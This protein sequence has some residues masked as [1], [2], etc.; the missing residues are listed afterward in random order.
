VKRILV[1]GGYGGFGSR[2]ARRL[3]EAGHE[4][5]VAG[6][7]LEKAQAFCA[8]KPRMRPL[9]LNR[10]DG[11]K[12]PLADER[13]WAVVDAAGPF[14]VTDYAVAEAAVR[15]GCHYI[16]IADARSFVAG[17]GALDGAARGARVTVLSG[18]SSTPALSGAAV[19][20]LA[21]SMGEIRAIEI[22]ISASNRATAGPS[23]TRAILSYVGK[24]V[25]LW[26]GGRWAPGY[27][28]QGMKRQSFEVAGIPPIAP[29]FVGLVD[30]PD[31]ELLPE[32]LAGRPAIS[33]RAGTE[34]AIQNIGLWMLSWPVRWAWL[35]SLEP[36]APLFLRA[37]RLTRRFGSDRSAMTV[38]LF[39]LG[40]SRLERRWT[41][42]AS[43]GD[44]P[45]IPGLAVPILLQ[46]LTRGELRPGARDA[47]N[48]LDLA[49]FEPAFAQLSIRHEVR[50]FEQ[51]LPLYE[52]VMGARFAALPDA[53][54]AMHDVLRD[55]GAAG[56]AT[57][58]QGTNF[59]ARLLHRA[60]RFPPEGEH[61]LHVD[62][63]ERNGTERWT[64]TFGKHHRFHSHLYERDGMLVERFGPLRF[65]FDLP[66]DAKGLRMA[67]RRWWLGP[68]PLPLWLAPRSAARE[69]EEDGLFWFDVP[70]ALPLIGL[71]VHYRGWLVP[72]VAAAYSNSLKR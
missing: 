3:W 21:K 72:S 48:L 15:A 34:L 38:R 60:M 8:G 1:L 2:I 25:P 50:D 16:D 66:S 58:R 63:T 23:V 26:R 18:A 61:P 69:W 54:R 71:I 12:K 44:G 11:L 28:W 47:G 70:I 17:I 67:M 5:V 46:R 40:S 53:V 45:E 49:E 56:R 35:G 33:F 6:R 10:S 51:P 59:H 57:V 24:P 41:L 64:R 4:V 14:Q 9:Q 36:L 32:R 65:A 19:R 42:I 22:A 31:L 68:I 39:G 30:V 13:P 55:G 43:D 62:F 52:R 20:M 29:R 27:G 7:S 37:Q